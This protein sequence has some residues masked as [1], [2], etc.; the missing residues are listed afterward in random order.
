[1][2]SNIFINDIR[3]DIIHSEFLLF[4]DDIKLYRTIESPHNALLLQW[5]LTHVAEWCALNRM[6]LNALK[7]RMLTITRRKTGA[8]YRYSINNEALYSVQ[9]IRD[10]GV[11]IHRSPSFTEHYS[12]VMSRASKMLGYIERTAA[13]FSDPRALTA[14]YTALVRPHL[15]YASPIWS[16]GARTHVDRLEAV[17][18]RFLRFEAFRLGWGEKP[19][20]CVHETP[21]CGKV[22]QSEPKLS[23]L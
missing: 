16:Q 21:G 11:V 17:Q 22:A 13:N 3:A 6:K 19:T 7:C 1:M 4:A 9:S 12:C 14:L 23:A 15:D 2:L 20:L 10:L 8:V 5:D 18:R